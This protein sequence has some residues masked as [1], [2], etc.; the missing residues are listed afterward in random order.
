VCVFPLAVGASFAFFQN[1]SEPSR[2]MVAHQQ[3][4]HAW[5]NSAQVLWPFV[6]LCASWW[7]QLQLFHV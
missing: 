7:S 2:F 4:S 3:V 6:S 5:Q 1:K